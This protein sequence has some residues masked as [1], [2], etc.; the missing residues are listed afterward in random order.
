MTEEEKAV[1]NFS[2]AFMKYTGLRIGDNVQVKGQCI[3]GTI[4]K[5]IGT[6]FVVYEP[7]L[8]GKVVSPYRKYKPEQLKR[9]QAGSN[10]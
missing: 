4:V 8:F 3:Y 9:I 2:K 10:P 5:I 6:Q 1:A 7:E